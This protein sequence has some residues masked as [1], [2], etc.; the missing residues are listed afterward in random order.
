MLTDDVVP[1]VPPPVIDLFECWQAQYRRYACCLHDLKELSMSLAGLTLNA[2]KGAL[3]L[4]AG[5]PAPTPEVRA[6][7]PPQFEFRHDGMRIAGSPIGTDAFMNSFVHEKVAEASLKLS[8]IAQ[9]GKKIPR[10]AHRLI[11]SC[12]TKLLSF[13]ANTVPPHITIPELSRY[14]NL[15]E[16]TFF[17]IVAP[18][19]IECSQ[20]RYDRAKLKAS[21]PTP[22]GCGLFKSADQAGTA[23][24]SSVSC[25]LSDP[26]LFSL[27]SG[28][29]RF[30]SSAY[31]T[32]VQMHG[33]E[34]SKFWSLCKHLYPD[35]TAHC[36]DKQNSI[37][38]GN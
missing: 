12:A 4:R 26:L 16:S 33:G 10:E 35:S 11:T 15:V 25:S 29:A 23:W 31:D 5:A 24:W 38:N 34:A 20:E 19:G 9:V 37:K 6:L 36:K 27:R 8:A 3:L 14:D 2:E 30:A 17:D 32:L 13:I 21:L 7:F 18:T 28:L 1:I 22:F